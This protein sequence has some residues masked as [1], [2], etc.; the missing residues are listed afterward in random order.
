MWVE[1]E[2][3][4][5]KDVES[6]DGNWYLCRI[7][8]YQSGPETFSGVVLTFVDMTELRAACS[9]LDQ[10]RRVSHDII[11][12]MPV[13][14]FIY[15]QDPAGQ[16]VLES[17]NPEAERLTGVT[18]EQWGGRQFGEIW[19]GAHD[20]G[21]AQQFQRVLE[22]G[23]SF[24]MEEMHYQDEYLE[25]EFRVRAFRLPENQLAV[26]F[27][28]VTD[29]IRMRRE[30][31]ESEAKYRTCLKPFLN[32]R[33]ERPLKFV[34]KPGRTGCLTHSLAGLPTMKNPAG[35]KMTMMNFY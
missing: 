22:T 14:L 19:P 3:A 29:Y 32:I 12:Y 16:L 9:D 30:L 10:I 23:E 35:R 20:A 11:H 13:G 7:M 25:G 24:Y 31:G 27:E 33:P 26:S 4:V 28:D 2:N 5:E 21:I 8:P 15:S 1:G 18:M 17:C 6:D 34:S